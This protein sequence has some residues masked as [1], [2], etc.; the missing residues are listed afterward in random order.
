MAQNHLR[1]R[2]RSGCRTVA[3]TGTDSVSTDENG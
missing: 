2:N 1:C 3:E